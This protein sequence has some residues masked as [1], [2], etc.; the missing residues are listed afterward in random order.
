MRIILVL[1]VLSA[2]SLGVNAQGPPAD[3]N[4]RVKDEIRALFVKMGEAFQK[5]DRAELESI[6]A[7]EFMFVHAS[8]FADKRDA[9]LEEA[10]ASPGGG[11]NVTPHI[12]NIDVYGDVAVIRSTIPA[13][14]GGGSSFSTSVFVKKAGKWQMVHMQGTS[15][16]TIPASIKIDPKSLYRY[17]GKY[18]SDAGDITV[19]HE[20]NDLFLLSTRFPRRTLTPTGENQFYDKLGDVFTFAISAEAK[21][22][23]VEIK[24]ANGT[25]RTWKRVE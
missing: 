21:A 13:R 10:L 8:G 5:K 19:V 7:P 24:L 3:L 16:V 11:L 4:A 2:S 23:Q 14:R 20:G 15:L 17:A 12:D 9:H 6:Y 18:Q 22:T 25:T 1:I